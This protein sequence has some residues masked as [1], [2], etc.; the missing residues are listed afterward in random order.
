MAEEKDHGAE[1]LSKA[2]WHYFGVGVL[3]LALILSGLAIE[4][5]GLTSGYLTS[6]LPGEVGT[7]RTQN[8]ALEKNVRELKDANQR[9][10]GLI[11]RERATAEALDICQSEK[12][13]ISDELKQLKADAQPATDEQP[14]SNES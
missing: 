5:L 10:D 12:K 6:I 14:A 4:R 3:W 1:A 8:A 2:V 7:L 9:L 11:G 13:Q